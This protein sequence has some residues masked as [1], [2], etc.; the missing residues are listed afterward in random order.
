MK[1][2]TYLN[3]LDEKDIVSIGAKNGIGYIYIGEAGNIDQILNEF[4][5]YRKKM[6]KK[7]KVLKKEEVDLLNG[8]PFD[9]DVHEHAGKIAKC[10]TSIEETKKYLD[11][12]VDPL[13]RDIC[14]TDK[15]IADNGVRI[16]VSGKEKGDFWFKYEYDKQRS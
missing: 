14:N 7:L 5:N 9:G 4:E 13:K 6:T 16:I 8:E 11:T 12:Y 3:K 10:F 1:L 2:K 15:R